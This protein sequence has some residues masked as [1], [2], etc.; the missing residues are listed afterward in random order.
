VRSRRALT[1]CLAMSASCGTLRP[2]PAE[3]LTRVV[4]DTDANN[5]VDDQH[6][7]AYMLFSGGT[8]DVEGITVNRTRG[9]GDIEKQAEEAERIVKLAG[10]ERVFSVIRGASGTYAEIAPNIQ[11]P[12][13][14][15]AAAVN[16]IIQQAHAPSGRP[17]VLLPVGKLTNIALALKKDPSIASMVRVVWLGSNYP[18]PGEYNQEN[19]EGALSYLLD[20]ASVPFEIAL[21][22]YGTPTGTDAVRASRDEIRARMPGKGPRI[23]EPITGRN[24]GTFATFGDYSVNL[25]DHIDLHGT[26][27]SRALYDMAAVAIVKNPA[28]ARPRRIP[29]PKLAA[30]KWSERPDNARTIVLWE[31][32]DREAIMRDFYATMERPLIAH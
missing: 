30:G 2:R 5:E 27:P 9:G 29:A 19:D 12:D 11:R 21:V 13:F 24:G 23:R 6:A 7:I 8:F 15:G 17:L 22:R 16:L 32:F 4:L 3:E 18:A 26:P 10:L 1:L 25:F 31:N 20:S 14:D 28:W